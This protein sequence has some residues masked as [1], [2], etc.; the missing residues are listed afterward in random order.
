MQ[1]LIT[2][3]RFLF[4]ALFVGIWQWSNDNLCHYSIHYF[5]ETFNKK[6]ILVLYWIIK[7]NTSKKKNFMAPFYWWGSTASRLEPLR[8]GSLLFTTSPQK[9]LVLTLSTSE[10]WKA[11]STLEPPS[12][13]EHRTPWLGIQ[14]LNHYAIQVLPSDVG[15]YLSSFFNP[16]VVVVIFI[17]ILQLKTIF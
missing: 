1:L 17:C 2:H 4:T 15:E 13:S 5:L 10:G 14:C 12:S 3:A 11:E 8:G 9:F 6:T 16:V 7:G